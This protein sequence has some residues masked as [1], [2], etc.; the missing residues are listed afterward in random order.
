MGKEAITSDSNAWLQDIGKKL[1]DGQQ[2]RFPE[3]EGMYIGVRPN[4]Q[5]KMQNKLENR[6]ESFFHKI[7]STGNAGKQIIVMF[8]SNTEREREK[9]RKK[10]RERERST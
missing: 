1:G 4:V 9:E 2:P 5:S 3:D 8:G 10:Q 7:V 6:S